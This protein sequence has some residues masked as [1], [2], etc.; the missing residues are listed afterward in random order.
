MFH[1]FEFFVEIA[2]LSVFLRK[3][4]KMLN[5]SCVFLARHS[6]VHAET[7]CSDTQYTSPHKTTPYTA[8]KRPYKML[9]SLSRMARLSKVAL[10]YWK[11]TEKDV[12]LRGLYKLRFRSI[13]RFSM[14][15]L[16]YFV[17]RNCFNIIFGL[18]VF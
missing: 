10:S 1:N 13:M 2:D 15:F 9:V 4:V 12:F 18:G 3:K 17:K 5:V 11:L 14:I 7:V 6:K 8:L 16:K